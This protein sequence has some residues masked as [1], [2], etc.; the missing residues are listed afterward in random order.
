VAER[1]RRLIPDAEL[2][3]LSACG[4]AP[5]LEWPDRFAAAVAWWLGTSRERRATPALTV[6]VAR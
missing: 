3:Y 5:M 4:H 6:G 2:L 1:F